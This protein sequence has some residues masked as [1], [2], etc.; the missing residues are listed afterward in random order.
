MQSWRCE[1]EILLFSFHTLN[2]VG[3]HYRLGEH[4]SSVVP[5]RGA[6]S[7]RAGQTLEE[8][9]GANYCT[10]KPKKQAQN[11]TEA[12]RQHQEERRFTWKQ[13]TASGHSLCNIYIS[14]VCIYKL[15]FLSVWLGKLNISD[16]QSMATTGMSLELQHCALIPKKNTCFNLLKDVFYV[17]SY[18]FTLQILFRHYFMHLFIQY[19]PQPLSF[20]KINIS[21]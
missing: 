15:C 12:T 13:T 18:K 9:Q 14:F 3:V 19:K 17:S 11:V 7:Y 5:Q 4:V 20:T 10:F 16:L 2:I 6:H 21:Y 1:T 8:Q